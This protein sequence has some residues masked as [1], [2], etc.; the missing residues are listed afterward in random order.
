MMGYTISDYNS[1]RYY[2]SPIQGVLNGCDLPDGNPAGNSSVDY[3]GNS[4]WFSSYAS[5]YGKFAWAMREAAKHVLYTIVNSNAMNGITSDSSFE[6]ITP[7]WETVVSIA[8]RVMA[9]LCGWCGVG[10]LLFW[11]INTATS[12][13]VEPPEAG[14]NK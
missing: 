13:R 1:S 9:V 11:G 6:I 8:P 10:F 12:Y 3:N 4:L 5:G 7:V 14:K 2:M